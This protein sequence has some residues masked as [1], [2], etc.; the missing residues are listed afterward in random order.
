MD[1]DLWTSA[2][3]TAYLLWQSAEATGAD[4]RAFAEQSIVQHCSMFARFHHYLMAHRTTV[5]SF[6]ADHIDGFFSALEH[7]CQPGTTTRLRY[8]KLIDRLSRHLVAHELRSDNPAGRM[9]A[10]EHWP[11][12]EPI[13]VYLPADEDA[14]LQ[15]VC[16]A[17]H[18]ESFKDLRN[19]AIVALFLGSGIT[20]A[21]LRELTSDDLDTG[22]ARMSV[23][24]KKHGPRIA[25]RV[26]VDP[27]AVDVLWM[28]HG[29]RTEMPCPTNWLF[30]A[31][32][33][34]KPMKADT[35]GSCVRTALRLAG[36]A[37]DDES[38]RLLRNTYGRRHLSEGKTNEQ[39]SALLGL[40]S[41][42]TAT[43]LRDTLEQADFGPGLIECALP[44]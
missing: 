3:E 1:L 41:H 14:R 37:A 26:P 35:L 25:R 24:V 20:A 12:D 30:V 31:T 28:Y 22:S 42:R 2:P 10:R 21:E 27:F 44:K 23:F 15:A 11:E 32:A 33:G 16:A 19:T 18:F 8:L 5:A 38:P 4:R 17:R 29:A 7:D 36:A 6:G 39:V 43:R 13:P 40:S 9:L 34:G